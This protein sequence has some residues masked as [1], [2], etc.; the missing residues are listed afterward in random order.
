MI[1][2]KMLYMKNVD[3][4][5][6]SY[7][8]GPGDVSL[9][10]N[11]KVLFIVAPYNVGHR[12]VPI[13]VRFRTFVAFPYGPLTMASYFKR[14]LGEKIDV[15][16]LDC[17]VQT[18]DY[19][20]VVEETLREFMPDV[21]GISMMFDTSYGHIK[22]ISEAIN[23]HNPEIPIVLGGAAATSFYDQILEEQ[24]HVDAVCYYEGEIPFLKVV[25][26]ENMF[27]A[28]EGN[29]A[30]ITRKS[31]KEGRQP[32]KEVIEDLDEIIDVDYDYVDYRLYP[33]GEGFSPYADKMRSRIHFGM[34]TSRGCAFIC[35]FCMYSA[36]PDKS[37]RYASIPA[38]I[39]HIRKLVDKYG[40]NA[41]SLYDDQLLMN[42]P[43]AKE[44]FEAL[45]EFN[46]R[47]E[48]PSGLTVAFFD[49]ELISLMKKAGMDTA[50]LAI[51]SGS[52]HVL[53]KIIHKPLNLKQVKPVVDL[54]RKYN[55]WSYGFF[56]IGMPGETDEHRQETL[57]FIRE[58]GLDWCAFN[59]AYPLRGTELYRICIENGYIQKPK[60]GEHDSVD[61]YINTPEYSAQYIKR[62]T[63][64]MNL[65]INFVNNRRMNL[66][67]HEIAAD[68]FRSV[69]ARYPNHVFAYYFL[70]KALSASGD[71]EGAQAAF[72]KYQEILSE[73]KED[74]MQY[75]EHFGLEP[76]M[77]MA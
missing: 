66:G 16:I 23:A 24:E 70:S 55:I 48:C 18:R 13:H 5:E 27:E 4:K 10:V 39:R 53:N 36:D 56:V 17:N 61:T 14:K 8:K 76:E 45:A 68:A 7:S 19:M 21:V 26:S 75:V 6:Q 37:M 60:A 40:A 11:R 64:L 1:K 73:K 29:S 50:G 9:S 58:S 52:P 72:D 12:K 34:M 49:E 46:F 47:I 43:R 22:G 38:I 20:E 2:M 15:K 33:M 42:K 3:V 54:L 25:S 63:Y 35:S 67:D 57:D 28:I 77:S 65:D 71:Q 51:E 31:L 44:L 32:L 59:Q 69:I 41:L 74:W 62:V 30:W